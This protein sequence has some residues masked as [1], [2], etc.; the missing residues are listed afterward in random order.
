M[1]SGFENEFGYSFEEMLGIWR[2]SRARELMKDGVPYRILWRFS[3][4]RSRRRMERFM[5]SIAF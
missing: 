3:G 5:E 4:F 2:L 1:E